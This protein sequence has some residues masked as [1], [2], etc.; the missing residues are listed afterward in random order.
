M[1]LA[2]RREKARGDLCFQALDLEPVAGWQVKHAGA[3]IQG[4]WGGAWESFVE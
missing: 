1:G 3:H 4:V 2:Q